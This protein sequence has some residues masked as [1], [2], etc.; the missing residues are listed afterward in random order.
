MNYVSILPRMVVIALS[1]VSWQLYGGLAQSAELPRSAVSSGSADR[2][3]DYYIT[4]SKSLAFNAT[5]TVTTLDDLIAFLGYPMTGAALETLDPSILMDSS[6]LVAATGVGSS[7][8]GVGSVEGDILAAR[9]FAPKI[10]NINTAVPQPGWRKLVRF[11][12]HSDSPAA[13]AGI[14]SAIVLFNFF[15]PID[16]PPFSTRSVNTQV[17]LLAP[18]RDERL[19]W[20]DFGPDQKLTFALNASFDA[21]TLGATNSYFVPDGCNDCHGSPGNL[22]Q[23]MVNYLDTDHWFDRLNDDFVALKTANT[24]LLFDAQTNDPTQPQFIV[25][26]DVIRRFNA[27]ALQQNLNVR[28]A[29][30]E[31]QAAQTWIRLH[32]QSDEHFP[33]IRRAFTVGSGEPWQPQEA[34]GLNRLNRY[35]FRCHG[36][37]YF[38]VF[39]RPAVIQRVGNI[40]QRLSP[41]PQQAGRPG[42]KMPPDRTLEP[43]ELTVLNDFLKQLK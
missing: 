15:P 16:A 29:G 2:A 12:I 34:E 24:P 3:R 20:L 6:Q 26:F 8:K 18:K 43:S 39:D 33:P 17:M 11:R 23:P 42:F 27:E 14:E 9:F 31:T 19:L 36:S 13:R 38:S 4:I 40:R 35:C 7:Q 30:F 21:V 5:P 1:A 41:S 25:A 10:T 37:V 22:R 32:A 28:P